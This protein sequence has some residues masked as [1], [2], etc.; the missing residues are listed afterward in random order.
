MK[1]PATATVLLSMLA[2]LVAQEAPEKAPPRLPVPNAVSI[3]VSIE[4]DGGSLEQFVRRIRQAQPK[5]NIVLAS[6]ATAAQVPPMVLRNAG[7]EQALE[8]ACMAAAADFRV[9]VK[10]FRGPGEPV[11]SIVAER[12]RGAK[13]APA[14][15]VV[16][17]VFSLTSLS[18]ERAHG[19]KP[20]PV[21]T[22][23]S[24]LEAVMSD[25][26]HPPRV[27][28]HEDSGLLLARGTTAQIATIE[29]TLVALE[30]ELSRQEQRALRRLREPSARDHAK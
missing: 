14:D 24:A 27:R 15:R 6:A 4:F 26:R 7:I 21:R 11:Y 8:G 18:G 10:E 5:A 20:F 12:T 30:R 2:S 25:E 28:Y 29:E 1:N 16:R 23:L 22:I 3:T 9:R 13:P 17:R 19:V